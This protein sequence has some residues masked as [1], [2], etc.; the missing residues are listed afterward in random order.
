MSFVSLVCSCLGSILI[1]SGCSQSDNVASIAD[2]FIDHYVIN[3]SQKEALSLTMGDARKQLI[4]EIQAVASLRQRSNK[5]NNTKIFYERSML[6]IKE[7]TA[8]V[9]YD[10]TVKRYVDQSEQRQV[11]LL[12]NKTSD[13]GWLVSK[14]V[15]LD[16][17]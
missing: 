2:T 11:L 8:R 12:L 17:T 6:R 7:N 3:A 5:I 14:F 4:Q 10:I 9:V 16:G 15:F 13:T 1:L